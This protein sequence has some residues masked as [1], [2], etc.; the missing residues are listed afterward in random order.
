VGAGERQLGSI[1]NDVGFVDYDIR[2]NHRLFI[3]EQDLEDGITRGEYL[4]IPATLQPQF[5]SSVTLDDPSKWQS[6]RSYDVGVCSQLINWQFFTTGFVMNYENGF[7]DNPQIIGGSVRGSAITPIIQASQRSNA[8]RNDADALRVELELHAVS[9]DLEKLDAT[10]ED[11]TIQVDMTLRIASDDDILVQLAPGGFEIPFPDW[12][13][14]CPGVGD[15]GG[16]RMVFDTFTQDVFA[17]VEEISVSVT[18]CGLANGFFA[19]TFRD[20]LRE[21]IPSSTRS[22]FRELLLKDPRDLGVP[23]D[24]IR[25]CQCDSQCDLFAQDGPAYPGKRHVCRTLEPGAPCETDADCDAFYHEE[26]GEPGYSCQ[27]L[28]S[29]GICVA[30]F[31]PIRRGECWVQLEPDRINVRPDGIEY[32]TIGNDDPQS[33]V[34]LNDRDGDGVLDGS[35][36]RSTCDPVDGSEPSRGNYLRPTAPPRLEVFDAPFSG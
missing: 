19:D 34:M 9:V 20:A 24:E 15:P 18:G 28:G 6:F 11:V 30:E 25:G 3:F 13:Q 31:F 27:N 5:D 2:N 8:L 21:S 4:Q 17:T 29:G 14:Q 7:R 32:V 23:E 10:C 1:A 33:S 26:P 36:S 35:Y 12:P 16:T 22:G